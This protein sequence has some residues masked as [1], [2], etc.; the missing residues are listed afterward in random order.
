MAVGAANEVALLDAAT[1]VERGRLRGHT[2]A[3]WG[4]RFSHDGDLLASSSWDGTAIVWNLA[5]GDR[6]E[7]LRGHSTAL[8][9]V[10]F[11]PDDDTLYTASL[12]QQLLAWDLDGDRHLLPRR[13]VAEPA[14]SNIPGTTR[15]YVP[16]SAPPGNA[17][18][19]VNPSQTD[20]DERTGTVQWLDVTT[21][22]AGQVVDTGHPGIGGHAWRPDGRR[23]ATAGQ[24][25]FVRVW[26][27]HTEALVTER[28]VAGAPSW[29]STTS[30]TAPGWWW[31]NR[32]V[33]AADSSRSTPQRSRA[34]VPPCRS[35]S[36]SSR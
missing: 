13:S 32:L 21:R 30:A 14:T 18:A 19:Y 6:Q 34:R 2:Q 7:Q 29:G 22:R 1:L 33:E 3:V 28:Q 31:A 26:D 25:G 20:G 8:M 23:F 15:N 24:D 35:I 12:D 17:V 10:G 36:G 5:T 9:D 16:D 11:S 4:V 27:W